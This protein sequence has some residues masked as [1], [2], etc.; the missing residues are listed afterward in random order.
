MRRAIKLAE[1]AAWF[2]LTLALVSGLV[3]L[4]FEAILRSTG[5]L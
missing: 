5:D 4:V 2:A 1:Q 3:V